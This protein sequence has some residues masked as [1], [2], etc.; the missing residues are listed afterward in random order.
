MSNF[1]YKTKYSSKTA[2]WNE[3]IKRYVLIWYQLPN[4]INPKI[5]K[6]YFKC[7][8][9]WV[10]KNNATVILR[11]GEREREKQIPLKTRPTV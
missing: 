10:Y 5:T 2:K 1:L 8:W 4:K 11:E 6:L 7:I 9:Q 3:T